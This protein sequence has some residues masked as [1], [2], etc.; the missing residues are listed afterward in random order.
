MSTTLTC[1]Y[2][3]T[4]FD[5]RGTDGDHI[6]PAAFGRF[7]GE[8]KFKEICTACNTRIGKSEEQ[9]IRCSPCAFFREHVPIR[10]KRSRRGRSS[11]GA[12]GMPPPT[13]LVRSDGHYQQAAKT[14]LG[15]LTVKS[16]D[17]F[18][19]IEHDGNDRF[20]QLHPAIKL[21][22]VR[23][24]LATLDS[25][26]PLSIKEVR[27]HADESHYDRYLELA[28]DVWPGS[29]Y[30][31]LASRSAGLHVVFGKLEC[32]VGVPYWQAIAAKALHYTLMTNRRGWRGHESMFGP[33]KNFIMNGG[34][35]EHFFGERCPDGTLGIRKMMKRTDREWSHHLQLDDAS[36]CAQ[37]AIS[38]F[39]NPNG[40]PVTHLIRICD[41]VSLLRLPPLLAEHIYTYEGSH[42]GYSGTV[43]RTIVQQA[44]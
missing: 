25:H 10:G 15:P 30:R 20:V 17:Q 23:A 7:L 26:K 18:V 33:I 8:L 12:S 14:D 16:R 21:D 4:R 13:H 41:C 37:V 19:L 29:T 32:R 40:S 27:L 28:R 42:S 5:P 24:R 38:L 6:I 2:C 44:G 11:S 34:V 36:D 39:A 22:Q 35:A 43:A 9:L 31:E 1:I 3:P